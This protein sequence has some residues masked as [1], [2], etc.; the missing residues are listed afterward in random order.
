MLAQALLLLCSVVGLA[1]TQSTQSIDPNTVPLSTRDQW[2]QSQQISCPLICLQL[3]NTTDTPESNTCDPKT[4]DFTC[5]CSNGQSP[6]A[7]QYTQ[8]IPYYVCTTANEQCVKNCNGDSICQSHCVQDH[9]CGAQDPKR[10]NTT[11]TLSAT[12][13]SAATSSASNVIYTGFGAAATA[14][15]GK[16]MAPR[17]MVVEI[18]QVYGLFVVIAGLLGGVAVLL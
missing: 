12:S 13:S 2:C 3:P 15:P 6:N 18:G 5:V 16:G 8:T 1:T 11:A 14:A 4:L 17:N 7:S 9:P 10:V